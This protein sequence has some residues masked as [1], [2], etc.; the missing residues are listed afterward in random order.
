MEA[1]ES[2]QEASTACLP[3][4]PPSH[5]SSSE[6]NPSKE[7]DRQCFQPMPSPATSTPTLHHS[8]GLQDRGILT[9]SSTPTSLSERDV[10]FQAHPEQATAMVTP[11]LDT[12]LSFKPHN[13]DQCSPSMWDFSQTINFELDIEDINKPRDAEYRST[14][15]WPSPD[16]RKEVRAG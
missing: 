4:G 2:F 9:K 1:L 12:A 7:P 11:P 5:T 14:P 3:K 6:F 10:S 8:Y 13:N 16:L 15:E